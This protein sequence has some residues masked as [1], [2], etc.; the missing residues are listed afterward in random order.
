VI[1]FTNTGPILALAG[2]GRL[3]LLAKL[4]GTVHAAAAVIDEC[5][6]GGPIAVPE[7]SSIGWLTVVASSGPSVDHPRLAELDRGERDTIAAA[8]EARADYVII[9]ERLGRLAAER[10]GLAVVGSLGILAKAKAKG[11]IPSFRDATAG[12]LLAGI[13]FHPDLIE[14]VAASVGEGKS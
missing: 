2:I 11:L 7:L 1:V 3:D 10:M 4:F 5:R 9:D 14:K 13:R 12:M 8:H 6:A